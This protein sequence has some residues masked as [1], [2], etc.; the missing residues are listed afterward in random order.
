VRDE[1]ADLVHPVF[2][3][4]LELKH[5]LDTGVVPLLEVEQAALKGLLLSETEARRWALFGGDSRTEGGEETSRSDHFLGIRYALVCWLDEIFTLDSP[6]QKEWN[7][8]KLEVALYGTNDR[9]WK[10]WEQTRHAEA[11]PEVDVLEVF[12]LCVML[13]FAGERRDDPEKL[14]AW[15]AATQARVAKA[16]GRDWTPPP[17]LDPETRVPPLH[18]REQLQRVLLAG[19]LLLLVLIPLVAF[20]VV[21]SLGS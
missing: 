4:G 11:R 17:E 9:A 3:Y 18:G 15:L 1:I 19:S 20:V 12:F 7:E 16:R 10:F 14:E 8:R 13:G 2:S 5:R 21:Q 6:W